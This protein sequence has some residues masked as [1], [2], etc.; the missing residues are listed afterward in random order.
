LYYRLGK[1]N[2]KNSGHCYEINGTKYRLS[3]GKIAWSITQNKY[4]VLAGTSEQPVIELNGSKLEIVYCDISVQN[5]LPDVVFNYYN[6]GEFESFEK[7][8]GILASATKA[9]EVAY[10]FSR[11]MYANIRYVRD[12]G[13]S[14]KNK[15]PR[16]P[17]YGTL[18]TEI[19]SL[20]EC[21]TTAVRRVF[22][23]G[24]KNL[25]KKSKYD[26]L[27]N[28]TY[29][30][31]IET[32]FGYFPEQLYY[33]FGCLP[34]KDGSI[35]GT[36]ITTIPVNNTI[37]PM[38]DYIMQLMTN[39][40]KYVGA[41]VNN[42]L[43]VNIGDFTNTPTNRVAIYNL[44]R[45]LEQEIEAMIPNYKRDARYLSSKQG[46]PKDHCKVMPD[47]G[48]PLLFQNYNASNDVSVKMF[49]QHIDSAD[50]LIFQMINNGQPESNEYNR[51]TRRH[52][53][54]NQPKWEHFGRYHTLNLEPLY[55]GPNEA[56]RIEY[57]VHSGTV[58][59]GKTYMWMLICTAITEYAEKNAMAILTEKQK[60]TL[61]DVIDWFINTKPLT[62]DDKI[63]FYS[64]IMNYINERVK[65]NI[66][67]IFNND[68]SCQEEFKNDDRYTFGMELFKK[69][70]E[71]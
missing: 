7:P 29:G 18:Q 38:T 37:V 61:S 15:L 10:D 46:G 39:C 31:E 60:I 67:R 22:N 68:Q 25:F 43:H 20:S 14:A 19:Y 62:Q 1:I 48:F 49:A 27:L 11:G 65:E 33:R 42:S 8:L 28:K 55:I 16:K 5:L 34:L 13:Y 3:N 58:N 50:K 35:S 41:S 56:A 23:N 45:R 53:A 64:T 52:S 9:K 24:I 32:D 4:I 47:L 57:R 44:Y 66:V 69:L 6:S 54:A 2:Q 71:Q 36:E 30:L 12:S 51:R 59:P 63:L 40:S 17:T 21:D 70:I 26:V